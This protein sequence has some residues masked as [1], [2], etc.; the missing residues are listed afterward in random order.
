VMRVGM[1]RMTM[2]AALAAA[3]AGMLAVGSGCGTSTWRGADGKVA[4]GRVDSQKEATTGR[5][6]HLYIPTT[7]DPRRAYPLVVTFHGAFPFDEAMG[8]R[9]RWVDVAEKYGLIVCSP[10]GD[11]ATPWLGFSKD[12]PSPELERDDKAVVAIVKEVESRY[13]IN[14]T[15]I[16]ITGWSAGGFTAHYV[17]LNHPEIFRAIVGRC[18]NFNENIVSDD[19]ARRAR[20]MHVYLFFGEADWAGFNDMNRTANFW[21]TVRGFRNFVIRQLPGGHDPN[22]AEAARYF[23]NIINH[24]PAIR[25]SASATGGQAPLTVTFQALV[26][27]PDSPDGRVDSVLWNLGDTTVSAKPELS[28][29][30]EKPGLYNVFLTVK[31]LDGHQE[32]TQAWIKVN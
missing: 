28:H 8:Q 4:T 7:Y 14:K 15:A 16:M 9:N 32:Y 19:V 3:M 31:D 2:A 21:Y 10:D 25:I 12:H 5:I 6:Y 1:R 22:Q 18:S 30:Y 29:T 27:D 13:N 20:H 17:G 26:R 24:W 23:L 11:G